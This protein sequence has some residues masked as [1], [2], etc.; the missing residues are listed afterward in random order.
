MAT[1]EWCQCYLPCYL[2]SVFDSVWFSS[3]YRS[4]GRTR[5]ISMALG[6]T[7]TTYYPI[8]QCRTT[9]ALPIIWVSPFLV[10]SFSPWKD[11]EVIIL[12]VK[13]ET[14]HP[15]GGEFGSKFSAFIIIAELWG[16]EVAGPGNFVSNF[17]GFWGNDASQTQTVATAR[18]APKICQ[19]Q[20]PHWLTL[21][22]ISSKSVHFRRNYCRT[23]K[24]RFAP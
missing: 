13:M 1:T 8:G 21:F 20:P 19:G 5:A 18:I 14:I 10:R 11:F 9:D 16:P 6:H 24:D 7:S 22:Q 17:C 3:I 4:V 2:L 15:V 12:T 23:R